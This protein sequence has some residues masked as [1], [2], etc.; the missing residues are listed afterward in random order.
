MYTGSNNN[1]AIG[2][3]VNTYFDATAVPRI[4]V[5]DYI[6]LALF[7]YNTKLAKVEQFKGIGFS[8]LST[9][10]LTDQYSETPLMIFA[11]LIAGVFDVFDGLKA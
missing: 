7:D 1:F 4:L 10:D 9:Q 5:S 11:A 8:W 3:Q 2:K 6:S